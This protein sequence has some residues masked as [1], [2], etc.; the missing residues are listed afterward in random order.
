MPCPAA[1]AVAASGGTGGSAYGSAVRTIRSHPATTV[2]KHLGDRLPVR[3]GMHGHDV[4]VLQGFLNRVGIGVGV[5]G[6]F[7]TATYHA[8]RRFEK[9]T[10]L[11][12]NGVLQKGDLTRLVEVLDD[13][14]LDDLLPAPVTVTTATA[15]PDAD[16]DATLNSDGTATAPAS[17][18]L[19][20]QEMI[21]AAN[22]IATKPYRYGGGHGDWDDTGYDCSGSVSYALHGAGL[23]S[24][25]RDSTD[26]ETFG[27]AGKGQWVTIYTKASHAYVVIA[28]LRFDTSGRSA[29]GTRWQPATRSSAGYVVRHPTGL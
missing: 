27:Q 20:V 12:V 5:D 14:G 22:E 23:L 15:A 7:G 25:P 17:A 3:K 18:P 4:K 8:I 16:A 6:D 13:G 1:Q 11:P 19:P 29:G 10:D 24:V 9:R 21:A 28:G 2:V 26:L